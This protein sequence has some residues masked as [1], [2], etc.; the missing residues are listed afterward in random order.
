MHQQ[1]SLLELHRLRDPSASDVAH[2]ERIA[3]EVIAELGERPPVSLEVVASY[4]DI[5]EIRLEDDLPFAGSLTP[6]PDRLV[7]RLRAS[8]TPERRRFS[9][10]HEVGHT[11]QPGYREVRNFRCDSGPGTLVRD[12]VESLADVAG[13]ELLMPRSFFVADVLD[14]DFG[15]DTVVALASA[16]EASIEATALRYVQLRPEPTLLIVLAP[17]VRK[18]E[19]GDPDAV[20]ELRVVYSR[21]RGAWPFVPRNKSAERGGPL[22]RAHLGELVDEMATLSDLELEG[23]AVRISARPVGYRT[24]TGGLRDRVLALYEPTNQGGRRASR[25]QPTDR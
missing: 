4:R 8:D 11:F 13:A 9:G 23:P 10:F 12:P 21:G 6:G 3:S 14:A 19:R 18:S 25:R 1:L 24:P 2:V 16:Y 5:A 22:H 15:M 20:P 7:V 17:G